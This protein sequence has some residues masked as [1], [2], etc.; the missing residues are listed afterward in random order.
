MGNFESSVKYTET[1]L[2]LVWDKRKFDVPLENLKGI[3]CNSGSNGD[4][5]INFKYEDNSI[6]YFGIHVNICSSIEVNAYRDF[7]SKL[8][9]F[10]KDRKIKFSSR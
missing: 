7:L 2:N 1:T 9:L 10:C 3:V 6:L 8:S 5:D 4:I